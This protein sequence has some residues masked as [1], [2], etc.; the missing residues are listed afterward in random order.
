VFLRDINNSLMVRIRPEMR[1]NN[2]DIS[3][4]ICRFIIVNIAAKTYFAVEV[5]MFLYGEGRIN[6]QE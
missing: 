2:H 1:D 4:V 5:A 3:P 6:S